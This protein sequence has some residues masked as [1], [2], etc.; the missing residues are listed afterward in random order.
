M[1]FT[2]TELRDLAISILVIGFA[3]AWISR[4]SL[5]AFN[6]MEVFI[7]MLFGVGTAFALHE[8]AHKLSAQRFG[9]FAEY[10]MWE[11]GL[12][13]AFFLAV[14]PLGVVFAAPG[15]VYIA[16]GYFGLSRREDLII[17]ASGIVTNLSLAILFS[18]MAALF[19]G[20]ML[21][22]AFSLASMVNSWI[23]F[24]N[25][26]PIPPLDG[27]KVMKHNFG[28]WVALIVVAFLFTGGL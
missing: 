25:L 11:M 28:V 10:Q 22:T 15:A 1:R 3:F 2:P 9:C 13:L 7:I 27:S 16:P 14:S 17:S 5:G 12:I 24:F 4:D 23:A 26:L 19:Q 21:H 18:I 6:F 8:L 20:G